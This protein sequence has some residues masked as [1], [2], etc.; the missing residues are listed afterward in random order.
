[1]A[2]E[3]GK[4]CI[5]FDNR[6]EALKAGFIGSRATR[7]TRGSF[8]WQFRKPQ[9]EAVP[10]SWLERQHGTLIIQDAAALSCGEQEQNAVW[11]VI[12]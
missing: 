8:R 12:T 4:I 2:F 1:M 11:F 5:K 9:F 3:R 10:T 6:R 7:S